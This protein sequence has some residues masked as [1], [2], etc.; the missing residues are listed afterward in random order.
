MTIAPISFSR[1]TEK[2]RDESE[3]AMKQ[4]TGSRLTQVLGDTSRRLALQT[5]L[6]GA[7]ISSAR[8]LA[9][10]S[11]G[12]AKHHKHHK[13]KCKQKKCKGKALGEF[14]DTAKECCANE[15]NL[16]CSIPNGGS[17]TACCAIQNASCTDQ[18]DCCSGF[19]C[20]V[21]GVCIVG[22]LT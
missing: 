15:T 11:I 13:H 7:A 6:G 12:D 8:I 22:T 16:L 10:P 9:S 14:C 5:L 20:S 21:D 18:A 1:H 19:I 17:Q 4:T 3:D 2:Q